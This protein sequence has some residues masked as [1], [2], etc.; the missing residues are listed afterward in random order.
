MKTTTVILKI[1]RTDKGACHTKCPNLVVADLNCKVFGLVGREI[2]YGPG[3]IVPAP[4]CN[5]VT[6][7]GLEDDLPW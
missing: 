3:S 5:H 2:P 4:A 7:I 6:G 1:V